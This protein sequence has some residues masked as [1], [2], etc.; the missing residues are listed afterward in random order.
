VLLLLPLEDSVGQSRKTAR[1]GP[2]QVAGKGEMP[3]AAGLGGLID[4]EE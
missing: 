2:V 3:M 4:K 1:V